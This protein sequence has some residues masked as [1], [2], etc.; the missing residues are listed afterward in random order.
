MVKS[1][2]K[3]LET[4]SASRGERLVLLK[5][6]TFNLHGSVV[7]ISTHGILVPRSTGEVTGSIGGVSVL[8]TLKGVE[9]VGGTGRVLVPLG[10][11]SLLGFEVPKFVV[12]LTVVLGL[13]KSSGAD[14]EGGGGESRGRSGK[15][16]DKNRFELWCRKR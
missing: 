12:I 13:V 2:P 1:L 14:A 5:P 11:C 6:S 3:N 10:V 16:E 7:D 9:V 4:S 15:G 8:V